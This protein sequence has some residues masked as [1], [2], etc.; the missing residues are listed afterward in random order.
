M[1]F[2]IVGFFVLR[3]KEVLEDLRTTKIASQVTT[4]GLYVPRQK[5]KVLVAESL[6]YIVLM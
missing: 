6:C 3:R 1:S 4:D 2:T 5:R